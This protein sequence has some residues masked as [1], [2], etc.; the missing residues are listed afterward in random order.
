MR[1]ARQ[2][3][4]GWDEGRRDSWQNGNGYQPDTTAGYQ[5]AGYPNGPGYTGQDSYA[6][7]TGYG[8]QA[9]GASTSVFATSPRSPPVPWN[10]RCSLG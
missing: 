8:D 3:D 6:S 7:Q 1:G 4:D 2:R 5:G 10:V 9:S